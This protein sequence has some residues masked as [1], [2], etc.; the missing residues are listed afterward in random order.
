MFEIGEKKW[1][2]IWELKVYFFVLRE[3]KRK[4]AKIDDT[5]VYIFCMCLELNDVFQKNSFGKT[6]GISVSFT[7]KLPYVEK[8][9]DVS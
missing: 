8:K 7:G 9:V 3:R 4:K 2:F 1:I 6:R 5:E